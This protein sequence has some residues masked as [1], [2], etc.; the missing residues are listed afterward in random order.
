MALARETKLNFTLE[1]VTDRAP[2]RIYALLMGMM[3]SPGRAGLPQNRLRER[4]TLN[5]VTEF[6]RGLLL[7]F[8]LGA[9]RIN[10][11]P[12]TMKHLREGGK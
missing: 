10:P 3:Y 1:E 11:G 2:R 7:G 9:G 12:D 4:L 6:M 5:E 8:K